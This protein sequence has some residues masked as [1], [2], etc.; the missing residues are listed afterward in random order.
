MNNIIVLLIIGTIIGL[1]IRKVVVE[2]KKGSK[3]VGCHL[4][5]QQTNSC[6]CNK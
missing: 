5:N 6:G 2:K 3:C 1:A 4:A